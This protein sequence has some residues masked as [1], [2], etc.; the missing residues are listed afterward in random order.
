MEEMDAG[1]PAMKMGLMVATM[2][3][4]TYQGTANLKDVVHLNGD[5]GG[6]GDIPLAWANSTVLANTHVKYNTATENDGVVKSYQKLYEQTDEEILCY[7]HDDVIVRERGWDE[8]IIKEFE[9]PRVALV[10]MGGAKCHGTP[11]LYKRSY[12]LQNLRRGDYL[13]NVDDAEVHGARFTGSEDVAV[14]DGFCLVIRRSV[15][16]LCHGFSLLVENGID[17]LCYDYA[18]C[19]MVRRLGYRIRTV[20]VRCHH[21]GGGTSV[22]LKSDR[23]EEYDRSHRWFYDEFKDV[24]PCTVK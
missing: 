6:P 20:G 22:A 21:R 9:D 23:Q 1:G 18:L 19:A 8:K 16:D 3:P 15:L 5:P 12:L 11:D 13:S 10:G 7:M 4:F 17:F 14:L 2:R 24:M